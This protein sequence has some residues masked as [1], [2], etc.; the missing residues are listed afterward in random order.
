[1]KKRVAIFASGGGTNAEKFFEYFTNSNEIEICI[2]LSNNSNAYALERAKNHNTATK[3]F[4]RQEFQKTNEVL[5]VLESKRIDFI[6]L[7]GFLWLIPSNIIKAFPD[8]IINIHPA[9]LPKYGGKGMYG[10][11]VHEAVKRNNETMSGITIH[12]VSEIYDDGKILF[13]KETLV[14]DRDTP[15][16]IANKVHVLE[17]RYFPEVVEKYVLENLL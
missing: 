4:S 1:L 14:E 13:Q 3:V 11:N 17:H 8:R 16:D 15:V 9:L 5:D 7:A 6:I 12:L 10:M 2:L